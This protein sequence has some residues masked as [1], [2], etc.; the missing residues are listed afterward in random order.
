V[1]EDVRGADSARSEV[2][3]GNGYR[4]IWYGEVGRCWSQIDDR[5]EEV[6]K[7]LLSV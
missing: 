5:Y 2:V 3:S 7:T 6:D 1:E 4:V